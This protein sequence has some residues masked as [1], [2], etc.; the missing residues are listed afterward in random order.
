MPSNYRWRRKNERWVVEWQELTPYAQ[1]RKQDEEDGGPL[2]E[3]DRDADE[4]NVYETF[5]TP[6][7]ATAYARKIVKSGVT[8]YG[9]ATVQ[10]ERR[11]QVE[12]TTLWDWEPV[13]EPEYID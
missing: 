10:L 4:R 8:V 12:G 2:Y 1:R 7:E 6:D 5:K 13:G 3:H 11:E 9:H